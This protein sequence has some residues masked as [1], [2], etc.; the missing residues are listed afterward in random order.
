MPEIRLAKHSVHYAVMG[1]GP[2]PALALHCSLS[3]GGSWRG[4]A[5]RLARRVTLTAFD[6]PGHGQSGDWDG[7]SEIQGLSALIAAGLLAGPADIL[8][9]SFGATV[10]LRLAVERPDLVR[11]LTLIEPVFFA[12]A[13]ADDPAWRARLTAQ[14]AGYAAA[15]AAGDLRG[16]AREFTGV[17]GGGTAWADLPD[18]QKARMAARM[19]LV[20]AGEAALERDCAGLL[21][22]GGVTAI[23]AP[24]LL[25]AGSQSPAIIGAINDGLAARLADVDRSVIGGAGHMAPVNHPVQVSDEIARFL[26]RL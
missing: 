5:E 10:A 18:T 21:Q 3:H 11:S 2:R 15:M 23:T 4:V 16:A 6:L 13:F 26:D 25:L 8:G 20:Q 12:V 1:T 22:E 24:A 7:Q 9:H 14:M 19:P 17:W